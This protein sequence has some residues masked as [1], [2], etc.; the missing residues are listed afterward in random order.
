MRMGKADREGLPPL[1][2]SDETQKNEAPKVTMNVR[3]S[4]TE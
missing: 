3:S 1:S 4:S 2:G